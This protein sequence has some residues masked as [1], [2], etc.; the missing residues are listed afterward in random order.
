MVHAN[1]DNNDSNDD[2]D[3]DYNNK[4]KNNNNNED[5]YN[6]NNNNNDN[7]ND[8]DNN[9]INNITITIIMIIITIMNILVHIT[10]KALDKRAQ[11]NFL[12]KQFY[13]WK[14][15]EWIRYYLSALVRY[16]C[17]FFQPD[18]RRLFQK[19]RLTFG[20]CLMP[21]L[22]GQYLGRVSAYHRSGHERSHLTLLCGTKWS[23]TP[24]TFKKASLK[25]Q[26]PLLDI[27]TRWLMQQPLEWS[28]QNYGHRWSISGCRLVLSYLQFS[29]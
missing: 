13:T 5:N 10:S 20:P 18:R 2:N 14:Y 25:R 8:N 7:D 29:V 21:Q 27:S 28:C 24:T 23:L 9:N 22:S 12:I 17:Y 4:N 6:K 16:L 19:L 3:N 11:N 26:H 15:N 1:S